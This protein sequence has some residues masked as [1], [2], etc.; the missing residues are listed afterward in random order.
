[1]GSG[2]SANASRPSKTRAYAF[3]KIIS[4]AE[5]ETELLMG[6]VDGMKAYLNGKQVFWVG[7][8]RPAEPDQHR[9]KV[10]LRKG[11]NTLLMKVLI[12]EKAG[13]YAR[14]RDPRGELRGNAQP[15]RLLATDV[16]GGERRHLSECSCNL[17]RFQ[18][19]TS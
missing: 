13:F 11:E 19:R 9:V 15:A 2:R 3:A 10:T 4:P 12:F 17:C 7:G 18:R 16:S 5:I 6:A 8:F 14:F 1:M